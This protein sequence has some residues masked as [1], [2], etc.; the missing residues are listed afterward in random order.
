MDNFEQK[1]LIPSH[2]QE[3]ILELIRRY[4]AV[5][6]TQLS[7]ELYIN[8]AT[9]RRY[10]NVLAKSGV[11]SRTYG[12]AVLNEG[13]D[14]EIPFFVR[15]TSH[16]EAKRQ[17]G[18]SAAGFIK[19]GDTVFF[20]SSSTTAFIIPH[21]SQKK[22]L[23][24]VT[25]GAKAVLML[26]KLSDCEIYCI[27][28]KLRENSLS[29]VGSDTLRALNNYHFDAAFF[30]CRGIDLKFGLT[31]SNINEA[32]IRRVLISNAK[33]TYVLAD[34]SKFDVVSF[35]TIAELSSVSAIVTNARPSENWEQ[36]LREA[37]VSVYL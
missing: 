18:E 5:S 9:I 13:L 36:T 4:K 31:D 1:N 27:G 22:G 10:L 34:S 35:Y 15:E 24:I 30:S 29:F 25:N 14:S 11:I 26:S 20:D 16:A 28:G 17:I 19:D 37:N 7:K 3:Y 12:G 23:R 21:L 33:K 32:E 8:E 6:V 2:R